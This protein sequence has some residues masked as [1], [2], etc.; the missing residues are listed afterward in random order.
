[1]NDIA[2]TPSHIAPHLVADVDIYAL[3]GGE[4]DFHAAWRT[5]QAQTPHPFIWTPRNGGH[6]IAMGG[7]DVF[8]T[9]AD[10]ARFSSCRNTLP[11]TPSVA[12]GGALMLDPPEH[13]PFRAFLNTG[14]SPKTVRRMEPVIR[15]VAIDLIEGFAARGGCEFVA[16]F[17]DVLPLTV[18]LTLVDLPLTDRAMLARLAAINTRHDDPQTR[19]QA[20]RDL[21]AYVRPVLAARR[22]QRGDDPL[23]EVVHADIGGRTMSENEALGAA[24][25][26]MI[27]GLDTV[28]SLLGFVMMYLA[29][30]PAHRRALAADPA[31]I[32]EA[33]KELIR[34]F[35]VVI[36]AREVRADVELHGVLLKQG[37][38]VA[39][40]TML[41]N[42][43]PAEFPDP[44]AADFGRAVPATCTF[45]N[46][47]HR[48]PGAI[49]G[50]SELAI[51]LEEWLKRIPAFEIAP[52]E[53]PQVKGGIV[54]TVTRLPLRWDV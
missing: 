6:W 26:L 36:A 7:R 30:E 23:S 18:F 25:H 45:G 31:S 41:F 54:A 24:T 11:A 9:F 38:M 16:E 40:P 14:L 17:A 13:Q 49:L 43:D 22:A 19:L 48:C 3:P 33:C 52:G 28:S 44:L 2:P 50:R 15:R 8:E 5:F 46:G 1:M 53:A 10:H 4:A 37:D 34:R 51:A 20:W 12:L 21:R 35:P 32:P 27:A 42:L 29:R 47:V 39:L